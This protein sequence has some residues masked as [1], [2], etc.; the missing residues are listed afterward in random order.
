MRKILYAGIILLTIATGY[1]M[2]VAMMG[3]EMTSGHG[4]QQDN[5]Q[6]GIK[7]GHSEM[8]SKKTTD[9]KDYSD[10]LIGCHS[11]TTQDYQN[12]DNKTSD[13]TKK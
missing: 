11:G 7:S 6:G 12:E 3:G 13:K 4:K 1:D 8:D 9:D 10:G 2:G 5:K